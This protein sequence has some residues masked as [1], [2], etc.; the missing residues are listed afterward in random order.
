MRSPAR[1]VVTV[2]LKF[3]LPSTP[4]V[5]ISTSFE[6][7]HESFPH[8]NML[9]QEFG[10]G[11]P[12]AVPV[13]VVD[14][15]NAP[16]VI[17]GVMMG[18]GVMVGVRVAVRVLVAVGVLLGVLVAVRVC[19]AVG[20]AVL[21]AVGVTVAL[22]VAVPVAVL[23]G[24]V[25]AVAVL[26][27]VGVAVADGGAVDVAVAVGDMVGVFVLVRVCVA[28]LVDVLVPVGVDVAVA[29]LVGVGVGVKPTT[30]FPAPGVH[31]TGVSITG[32]FPARMTSSQVVNWSGLVPLASPW[33]VMLTMLLGG[34][35]TTGATQAPA[36]FT[37]PMGGVGAG[38]LHANVQLEKG[39]KTV[40]LVACT[41]VESYCTVKV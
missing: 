2:T 24:E 31:P 25:V 41:T 5:P 37:F 35:G 27:P 38:V 33:N 11:F 40:A 3:P 1:S 29:V 13:T 21:V 32:G 6:F 9:I 23:V 20:D 15:P 19:V 36:Q 18:V 17:T 4:P 16:P 10:L 26:V 28:L 22:L 7:P 39:D 12:I 34:V 30:M 8:S 14:P